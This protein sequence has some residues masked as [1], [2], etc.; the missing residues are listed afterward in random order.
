MMDQAQV[1]YDDGEGYALSTGVG[2][3]PSKSRADLIAEIAMVCRLPQSRLA[4]TTV[5]RIEDAG[6]FSIHPDGLLPSHANID[7]GNELSEDGVKQLI[8]LFEP[9]ES[10][11]VYMHFRKRR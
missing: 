5:G 7:L 11:P 9:A 2:H 10:N 1:S 3:D 4:V 6:L 8:D